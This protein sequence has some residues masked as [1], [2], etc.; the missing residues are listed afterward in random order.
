MIGKYK[1]LSHV[2]YKCDYHIVWVPKYRLLV[3]A[4]YIIVIID[5]KLH[6]NNA[7]KTFVLG[8]LGFLYSL[9]VIFGSGSDTVFYG[10]LLL[11]AGIPFYVLMQWHKRNN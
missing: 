9:W 7:F 4:A 6:F 5:K 8:T 10:F 2:I 3:A 11:M 1:K